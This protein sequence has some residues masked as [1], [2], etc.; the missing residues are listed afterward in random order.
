M[1]D[2]SKKLPKL[3]I[4]M[5]LDPDATAVIDARSVW[6]ALERAELP[7]PTG[8]LGIPRSSVAAPPTKPPPPAAPSIRPARPQEEDEVDEAWGDSFDLSDLAETREA[9]AFTP[10]AEAVSPV[11]VQATSEAAKPTAPPPAENTPG[12]T[13]PTP[14]PTRPALQ[15]EAKPA[16]DDV[17]DSDYL[18][19][20]DDDHDEPPSQ[21]RISTARPPAD[22]KPADPPSAHVTPIGGMAA[23]R[24]EQPTLPPESA[25]AIAAPPAITP[26]DPVDSPQEPPSRRRHGPSAVE[27]EDRFSIGDFAGAMDIAEE[28]LAREATHADAAECL[29][30]CRK[31]LHSAYTTKLGPLDR[32]PLVA[33]PREQLRWL[34][35]DH[36]AGFILSH[37]DGISNLEEIVDISGMPE[38]DA[39]RILS[40]LAQQRIIAFR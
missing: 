5:D 27:M 12:S 6:A 28:L 29:E 24:P 37:V 25:P 38:L 39:L 26:A 9:P 3:E 19:D 30:R 10:P 15:S 32:V 20:I 23:I 21:S 1:T 36:R 34:T 40:E 18:V 7:D 33:I 13:V 11:S 35:I 2:D 17:L 16:P 31:A 22:D 14:P 8:S 4:G